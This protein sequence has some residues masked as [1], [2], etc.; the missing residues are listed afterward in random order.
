MQSSKNFTNHEK[1]YCQ[2][3]R[4]NLT[5]PSFQ[6]NCNKIYNF[7]NQIFSILTN[8]ANYQYSFR[9]TNSQEAFKIL[10][11]PWRTVGVHLDPSQFFFQ[12]KAYHPAK[13]ILLPLP[14]IP[15]SQKNI[16]CSFS[17][18]F[19]ASFFKSLYKSSAHVARSYVA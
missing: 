1:I 17:Y 3:F 6:I 19:S 8:S 9:T 12:T 4:N 14:T 7:C 13:T 15:I 2:V 18:A 5:G 16:I 10:V 11:N